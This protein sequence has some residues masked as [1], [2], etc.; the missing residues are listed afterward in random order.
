M[1]FQPCRPATIKLLPSGRAPFVS[2]YFHF[3]GIRKRF[4]GVFYEEEEGMLR[5]SLNFGPFMRP[6]DRKR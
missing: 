3:A 1:T 2:V 6:Q 5:S 4:P